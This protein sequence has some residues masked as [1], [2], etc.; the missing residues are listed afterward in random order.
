LI[1]SSFNPTTH[2]SH[3]A[4]FKCEIATNGCAF[5]SIHLPHTK[6]KDKGNKISMTDTGC[7]CSPTFTF[8]HHLTS[9]HC[10]PADAPLFAFE[11]GEGEW[12]PM[13]WDWFL[14]R[15]N[16]VWALENLS[17]VK[18]HGFRIGGT[19]HLLLL[20]VDPW[21][22]MVQER[23]TSQSFLS[24]WCKCEEILPLFIGFL[25]QSHE[26]ILTTMSAFKKRLLNR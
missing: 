18:G 5:T 8:D 13:R 6:T 7:N 12:S 14:V 11:T 19:T 26:S 15:C 17:S 10:V 23:W 2:I 9:N 4:P 16:Q 1:D 24:Y 20:S 25:F 3:S 21:I 22:V